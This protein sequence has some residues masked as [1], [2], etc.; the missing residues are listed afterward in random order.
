[1]ARSKRTAAPWAAGRSSQVARPGPD[2]LEG[3]VGEV[4][5]RAVGVALGDVVGE[6]VVERFAV[7]DPVGADHAGVADVDRAGVG[8][9]EADPEADQEEGGD[10]QPGGRPDRP[11][12]LAPARA[13][14][15][16][17]RGRAGRAS[18]G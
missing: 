16:R 17:G 9:V 10:Q 3:D 18:S 13:S 6:V 2:P 12:P 11:Q 14:R 15:S 4:V 7:G 8:D 1:M 5:D